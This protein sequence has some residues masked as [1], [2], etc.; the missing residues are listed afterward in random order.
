M[1]SKSKPVT[2]PHANLRGRNTDFE[3]DNFFIR[4]GLYRYDPNQ[5][6]T[7]YN[8]VE[9]VV[10]KGMRWHDHEA[11]EV[12]IGYLSAVETLN[13]EIVNVLRTMDMTHVEMD[14]F[15]AKLRIPTEENIAFIEKVLATGVKAHVHTVAA[16]REVTI[17]GL[18]KEGI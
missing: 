14:A 1:A 6:R 10:H 4:K 9:A 15:L 2:I 7:V 16:D 5:H 13:V 8:A 18:I 11:K 17:V 12:H 3:G